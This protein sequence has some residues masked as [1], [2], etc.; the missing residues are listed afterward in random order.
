MAVPNIF[1]S[2]TAAIPLSQLDTNFAT[3]VTIGNT[4]V[5]LGN[6][7]TSFGNVTLTNVTIN[8]GNVT[9]S[10][11]SNTAPSITTVGD[12]NTGIFFP[13]ADTIAFSE[14]GVESARIDASG[15]LGL[16]VTPS[17]WV[18]TSG[19]KAIEIGALGN[20][21]LG[22]GTADISMFS[23]AYINTSSQIT[24]ANNGL[25]ARY[26][27]PDGQHRWYTAASGTAG[28][29]IS[30][31]QAMTLNESGQLTLGN[32]STAFD[33]TAYAVVGSGTGDSGL[34][35]FTSNATAGY[36]QFADGTSGAEEY[37]G[38]IKYDHSTNAMSFSTNSSARS[39]A[40]MTISSSAIVTMS[41][42]GAGA[43]TFSAA[44]VISSVSDET[45]KIKD[46]VPIDTD[47]MLNKLE[48]GYWYYNDEKKETFGTDRQ[49][50]FYA[51]NVNAAIGP[52]A[53]PIPEEGK[54]WGYYDRSVLAI[55]VISLQKA[56]AT[57]ESLNDRIKALENK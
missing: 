3:P 38:F 9:V 11:G 41:A 15:N 23:N 14:G 44:G 55:T 1:G 56:L 43:A 52:E 26:Q 49:L 18:T 35:I 32:T 28:N 7:V 30:F 6:T 29:A 27:I 48:P 10:A 34:A 46:G 42:Y 51:Q 45:W 4:A 12:T 8:S 13:A 53:A 22:A 16:G 40:D 5:Q 50:G 39:D 25:A 57:I 24:Y 31:T 21:L 54:P 17:A 36:L 37:R 47:S 2:A 33:S 20:A 19:R